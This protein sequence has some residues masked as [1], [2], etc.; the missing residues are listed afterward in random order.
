[1]QAWRYRKVAVHVLHSELLHSARSD[2]TEQKALVCLFA[3]AAQR[4]GTLLRNIAF[5][6]VG[7]IVVRI[8]SKALSV[9]LTVKLDD[10]SSGLRRTGPV[11][12]VLV[13]DTRNIAGATCQQQSYL[14]T[15]TIS[16]AFKD[17]YSY[18]VHFM[19]KGT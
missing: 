9:R 4:S 15:T 5:I 17:K 8:K 18:G 11:T 12:R 2:K 7:G 1:M 3:A 14:N 16:R 13:C 10:C 6:L 19:D